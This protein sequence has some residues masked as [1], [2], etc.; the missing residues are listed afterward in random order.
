MSKIAST[1]RVPVVSHLRVSGRYYKLVLSWSA[2]AR[3]CQPGQFVSVRVQDGL[4]PLL[5]RPFGI[6]RVDGS[7]VEI[8]YE[9]VGVGTRRLSCVRPGD[10]LDCIGPL[11]RGFSL[12]RGTAA[13]IVIVAGGMGV[14]PLVFCAQQLVRSKNRK[15]RVAPLVLLG[16]R[17]KKGILCEREFKKFGCRVHVA[18]DDGSRGFR[19]NV[20]DLLRQHLAASE[21]RPSMVYGC[22]PYAML[23]AVAVACRERAIPCE[24]S[25]EAHMACGFG[26]CLG[27]AIRTMQGYKRV[28]AEG[29]VFSAPDII[30]ERPV[31]G[32]RP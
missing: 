14:A 29:P 7:R 5:R 27:C 9:V 22:G 13:G 15:E 8:L 1:R 25:L 32:R 11:G 31:P 3:R 17:S 10:Y 24:V 12:P 18:T 21:I 16:A 19:G 23:A 4:E 28:C 6:H 2:A 26:A 20:S 30:W